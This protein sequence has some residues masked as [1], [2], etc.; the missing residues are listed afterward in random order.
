[1]EK[2]LKKELEELEFDNIIYIKKFLQKVLDYIN[3]LK[4]KNNISALKQTQ[5]FLESWLS[6]NRFKFN[7]EGDYLK[8]IKLNNFRKSLRHLISLCGK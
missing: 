5:T 7:T 8:K 1:M 4:T 6:A 2:R 3:F